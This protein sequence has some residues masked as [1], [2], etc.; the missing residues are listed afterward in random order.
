MCCL[1]CWQLAHGGAG[2]YENARHWDIRRIMGTVMAERDWIA[3]TVSTVSVVITAALAAHTILFHQDDLRLV[4]GTALKVSRNGQDFTL[5]RQQELTFINSGNRPAVIS[6]AY[7]KLVLARGTGNEQSQCDDDRSLAKNVILNG[8]PI[9]IKPNEIQMWNTKVDISY[10][11]KLDGQVVRYY[12]DDAQA[13]AE[14][15]IVCLELYATTP[16]NS[17]FRWVRPLYVI[18]TGNGETKRLFNKDQPLDI[19]NAINWG[20]R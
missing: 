18:S 20:L 11:W 6:D 19:L 16:N 1:P 9:I 3:I 12:E 14:K 4:L 10:P 7:A 5:D 2:S 8:S 13:A 17:S 15:H